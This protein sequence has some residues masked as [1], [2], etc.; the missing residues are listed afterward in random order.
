MKKITAVK[1]RFL[2]STVLLLIV[3]LV[4]AL[5][6]FGYR[7]LQTIG[8]EAVKRQADATASENSLANLQRL[9]VTL[10]Q[11]KSATNKLHHLKSSNPLPQFDTE[12]SLRTITRQLNLRVKDVTF[13]NEDTASDAGTPTTSNNT[14]APAATPGWSGAKNSRVSFSFSRHLSY[15]ELINFLNAVETSTP[16][17]RV[18]GVTIP[19]D[20]RRDSINVGTITLELVTE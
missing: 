12:R 13:V 6:I 5:F 10:D 19:A 2:L 18:D 4:V 1:F 16:K 3:G 7:H 8:L 15:D 14:P 11:K 20:S 9:E 17:L